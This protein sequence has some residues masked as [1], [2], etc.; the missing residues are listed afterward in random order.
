MCPFPSFHQSTSL[1]IG[2]Y[3]GLGC[4]FNKCFIAKYFLKTTV[5]K[6][7]HFMIQMC[8]ITFFFLWQIQVVTLKNNLKITLLWKAFPQVLLSL[9]ILRLSCDQRP[10]SKFTLGTSFKV[11][12][13]VIAILIT[14]FWS[15]FHKDFNSSHLSHIKTYYLLE[16]WG[17]RRRQTSYIFLK[18]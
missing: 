2:L 15:S 11:I 4:C 14:W 10:S 17:K 13:S 6:Q 1:I 9:H 5:L 3:T 16:G 8:I 7:K 18:L 12:I